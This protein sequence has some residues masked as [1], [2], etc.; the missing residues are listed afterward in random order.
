M[1]SRHDMITVLVVRPDETGRS[2]EFLQLH[3]V[4]DDYLGDT[5]QL[6]RGSVNEGES[7]AAGALREMREEA[8]LIPRE[9]YRLGAV[10]S[11][12]TNVDD[13]LWHSIAFCAIV[14]RRQRVM[15]NEEHDAF[16]WVPRS[17]ID[18]NMMWASERL[19][20]PNLGRDIL[21]DG[22]AKPH[23]RINL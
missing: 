10:E 14:D 23:L 20:L 13:T 9:F 6:I 5:W 4:P 1:K 18:A 16:R 7:F 11:F 17:E 2:H 8:G 15:L 22:P 21:D 19:L 12:Y 3:R